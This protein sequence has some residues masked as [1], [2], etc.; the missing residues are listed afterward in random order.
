MNSILVLSANDFRST[1]RDPVFKGLLVFPFLS[2]AIVRWVFP[3]L[4]NRF[5]SIEPY[6]P[7]ILMWGCLQSA[8]MFGFIYGFLFL[9]EKEENIW[10]VIRVLPISGLK[11]VLSRLLI[12]LII[13]SMVNFTLIHWGRIAHFPLYQ[14]ILL[15]IQFSLAA[16]L[17]A[18]AL[19]AFANNR[20]EGLAQMKIVNMLLIIPGLIYILPYKAFHLTALIP[21]YWSFRSLEMATKNSADFFWFFIIGMIFYLTCIFLLNRRLERSIQS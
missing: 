17:I 18:L 5:P 2:F 12:G 15:S 1:F 7:V 21:T 13:S 11:L 10:Q 4:I 9:E 6:G 16:P 19:G 8:I 20:I 3:L 14:E